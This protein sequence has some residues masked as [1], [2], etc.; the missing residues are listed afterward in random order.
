ML[1]DPEQFDLNSF[2]QF[3]RMIGSPLAESGNDPCGDYSPA[4]AAFVNN[5]FGVD[6]SGIDWPA[7][8]KARLINDSF[9]PSAPF[10]PASACAALRLAVVNDKVQQTAPAAIG[11][12]FSRN[13]ATRA[14]RQ[15]PTRPA[16]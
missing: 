14:Q 13:A 10:D 4:A 7:A 6:I 11:Q 3:G 15:P 8:N 9:S 1:V 12:A 5:E 2:A 16:Q